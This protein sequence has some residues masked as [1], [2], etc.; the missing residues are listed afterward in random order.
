MSAV[1]DEMGDRHHRP[2]RRPKVL[3]KPK[4]K[5]YLVK[6]EPEITSVSVL[7]S[8]AQTQDEVQM[9]QQPPQPP[10]FFVNDLAH[11]EPDT[12]RGDVQLL[13]PLDLASGDALSQT[14]SAVGGH[15]GDN[16]QELGE[17]KSSS[18][19]F[20]IIQPPLSLPDHPEDDV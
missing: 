6:R 20:P 18:R 4:T 12:N 2:A 17:E 5:T 8:F 14:D 10:E 16:D 19:S 1:L 3:P 15:A 9:V 7:E 13:G 11:D